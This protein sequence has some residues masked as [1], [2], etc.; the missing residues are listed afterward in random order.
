[1][2][3]RKPLVGLMALALPLAAF[4][5][6]SLSHSDSSFLKSAEEDGLYE[7]QAGKIALNKATDPQ[8]KTFA[9]KLIDDH[10]KANQDIEQLAATKGVKLPTSPSLTEKA[11]LEA[12]EHWSQSGFDHHF[13][14]GVGVS[15]HESDV[16]EFTKQSMDAKD[17]DVKALAAKQLPTL[18]EH[19]SMAR[20]L[21]DATKNEKSANS[22][23]NK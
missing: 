16:K 18:Q 3:K 14:D 5:A 22:T 11:K 8:V 9:Q 2:L 1:M 6:D 13:A 4:A 20:Q 23:T 7:I 21:A 12:L 15:A 19:L 17:P 10:T